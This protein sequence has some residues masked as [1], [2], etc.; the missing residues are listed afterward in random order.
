MSDPTRKNHL[1]QAHPSP[2]AN[3]L[4]LGFSFFSWAVF[5]NHLLIS[6]SFLW[7]RERWRLPWWRRRLLGDKTPVCSRAFQQLH[8]R[9]KMSPVPHH[10]S[11]CLLSVLTVLRCLSLLHT[12]SLVLKISFHLLFVS[13][14]QRNWSKIYNCLNFETKVCRSSRIIENTVFQFGKMVLQLFSFFLFLQIFAY[15][16]E[17]MKF[18]VLIWNA[19]LPAEKQLDFLAIVYNAFSFL[20][21]CCKF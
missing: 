7:L 15:C 4:K 19:S 20:L 6:F 1:Y 8:S 3:T 5:Y 11:T 2:K 17:A 10:F 21:V 18:I 13:I 9:C 14:F 16:H 12:P